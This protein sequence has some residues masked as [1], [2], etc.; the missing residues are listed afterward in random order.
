MKGLNGYLK[1]SIVLSACIFIIAI[2]DVTGEFKSDAIHYA[3][4]YLVLGSLLLLNQILAYR[5]NNKNK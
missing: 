2:A 1:T 4:H 5:I 3:I